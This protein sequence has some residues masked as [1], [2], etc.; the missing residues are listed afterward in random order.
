MDLVLWSV[1]VEWLW[2]ALSWFVGRFEFDF[3]CTPWR[4]TLCLCLY[5]VLFWGLFSEP[6]HFG[7]FSFF[8][9]IPHFEGDMVCDGHSLSLY[10]LCTE[11]CIAS[12]VFFSFYLL[13]EN[14]KMYPVNWLNYKWNHLNDD[15]TECPQIH[16]FR[17]WRGDKTYLFELFESLRLIFFW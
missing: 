15:E 13:D 4:Y 17:V 3:K 16:L 2:S 12:F 5:I 1:S 11:W 8:R 6:N 7:A 10:T 14:M 9:N